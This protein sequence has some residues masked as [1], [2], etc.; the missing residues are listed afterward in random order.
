MYRY[1]RQHAPADPAA[2]NPSSRAAPRLLDAMRERIRYKHYS[3]RTEK[4]YLFWVRRFIR[5][6]AMR[7]PRTMGG[8]DIERYLTHL[9]TVAKVSPSTH[10]QALAAILF[11]YREVLCIELPWMG[12]IGRP[13][14]SQHVP[15][16]LSRDEVASLLAC[17]APEHWLLC[18]LLYG[19]G[20]R[21]QEGLMLR[22]KDVDFSRRV[23]YVRDGKGAKDRVVMLP[24]PAEAALRAQV[25]VS[26]RLW[27]QDRAAG[28]PGV[29][30]PFALARKLDRAAESLSW[31]WLFPSA[32]LSRDPRSGV[33]RRHY[34]YPQTV[35]RALHEAAR[36]AGITKRVTAHTLR[37]SFA[38]H[39]LDSGVDIRR[40][41]ELLGH[42]DVSTT[43]IYTHVL[44]SSAAGL[45]SPMELLPPVTAR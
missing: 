27:G 31:H 40:V 29:E 8:P 18:S 14:T 33:T 28:V 7:H 11:L 13:K 36:R 9:A 42:S 45:R 35:S 1:N 17:V 32:G 38:T 5:F 37:H 43:M 34:Q 6:H 4:A 15:V 22:V 3:L 24:A 12:E 2:G 16:V 44:S 26:R 20:L 10:K 19:A 23:L 39:L 41:Q 21:L 30:V 25:D